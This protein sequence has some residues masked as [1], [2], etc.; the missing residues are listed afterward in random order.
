M[1]IFSKEFRHEISGEVVSGLGEGKYYTSID[2]YKK[3]FDGLLGAE[4]FPGTLN[5]KVD[6]D[7]LLNFLAGKERIYIGKFSDSNRSYGSAECYRVKMN[8]ID[9]LIV[10]PERAYHP[11][12]IIEIIAPVCIREKLNVHDGSRLTLS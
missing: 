12:N 8:E 7:E 9:S 2:N 6:E 5:L 10:I 1:K 4:I 11:K 3:Q